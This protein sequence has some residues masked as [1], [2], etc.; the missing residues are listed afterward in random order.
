[1]EIEHIVIIAAIGWLLFIGALVY[2]IVTRAK[3]ASE[4]E[5]RVELLNQFKVLSAEALQTTNESFL[6]IAQERFKTWEQA[7]KGDLEKRQFAISE[8]VPSVGRLSFPLTC[9]KSLIRPSISA[10]LLLKRDCCD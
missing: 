7:N 3:L 8:L 2:A 5:N 6:N 10:T 4:K 1:M 9:S